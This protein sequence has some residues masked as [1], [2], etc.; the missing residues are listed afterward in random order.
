MF[1]IRIKAG[2]VRIPK[3][4]SQGCYDPIRKVVTIGDSCFADFHCNDLPNT[5]CKQDLNIPRYNNSC[6]CLPNHKPFKANKR[7]GLLEG[8]SKLTEEDR[9]TILGCS[10]LFKVRHIYFK[11]M[12]FTL[13]GL[14]SFIYTIFIVT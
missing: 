7:T 8:C 5:Y 14:N 4:S 10:T 3:S 12:N 1:L 11:V 9:Y 6:Q 2:H 13:L